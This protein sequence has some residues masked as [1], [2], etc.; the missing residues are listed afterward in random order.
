MK[1]SISIV[2]LSRSSDNSG[3]K[4]GASKLVNIRRIKPIATFARHKW[5]NAIDV[6]PTGAIVTKKIATA[7]SLKKKEVERIIGKK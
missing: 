4:K 3:I 7:Y 6:T 2:L 1:L 5:Q